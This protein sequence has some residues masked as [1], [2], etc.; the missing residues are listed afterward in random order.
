MRTTPYLNLRRAYEV[1]PRF[2]IGRLTHGAID[3]SP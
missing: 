3:A 1:G 2:S